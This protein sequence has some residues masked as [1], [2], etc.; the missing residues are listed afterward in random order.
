MNSGECFAKVAA[1]LPG[2][3][4]R[5]GQVE[6]LQSVLAAYEEEHTLLVEAGTG[7]GKSLAYLIPALLWAAQH[8]EPTVI[9]T[10]TIA[11]QEQLIQKDIPFLLDALEMDLKA[12][13]A[14]GMNNYVC[15]RKLHD[16]PTEVPESLFTWAKTTIEGSRSE[17]PVYP[18]QDLWD[19]IGAEAESCTHV[20]CPH[21]KECFFFKARR[22]AAD[23]HV[24]VA[25]HHLLF[26]DLAVREESDNFEEAA[27][28]PP[29]K[30][31]IL[32]EAHHI[33]D[34]ATHYFAQS[35]S[36]RGLIHALG[37][38]LSDRG[39]GKLVTLHRKICEA[40]P[41][42]DILGDKLTVILPAEKRNMVELVNEAFQALS[43]YCGTAKG[44]EKMRI[45]DSHLQDPVWGSTV[46][47]AIEQV[48]THGKGFLQT[49][50]SLEGQ[51][52]QKKDPLLDN[53][54]DGVLAEIKGICSRL[55]ASLATLFAFVF[56][57]LEADKVRWMEGA[58]PDLHL[59]AADLEIAQRL[60]KAL[61]E[62]LPTVVLCSATLSTHKDFSFIKKRLGIK[63]A[64]EKI[65]ASPFDYQ[66]QAILSVPT[67][68][69]DP[70]HPTF[71][72]EAAEKIW[73]TIEISKGGTFVLFTSYSM[74]R[75]CERLLA[76]RMHK[77]RYLL[78]CQGEENRSTLLRKF[79]T[80]D[81][82]VL[83]GTDSFWEGVD[84]AGDA[85]RCVIIVK[86]PF[87]VPNDP[88]FQARSEAIASQGGS[89][90][91]EYSLPHAIVKFKQGFGRL[92]RNKQD[93]GCVICLDPRLI[94]K[95][96]GKKFLKSLPPCPIISEPAAQCFES[97]KK[98]YISGT[99]TGF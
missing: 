69:P 58:P 23:A 53:K 54:C 31:L 40:Y 26:A 27:V 91:F 28:L 43:F 78:F 18:S 97:L 49:L 94:K 16:T 2:F 95:G 35:V 80:T 66:T 42:G 25:N 3:E 75:E 98:F 90:F 65:Y 45:R 37:R 12:V 41:L 89:P 46:Q 50:S 57:P 63:Q 64:E 77:K 19:Q 82:A 59:I 21:Y 83:F 44:E 60:S 29:Y 5:E 17:L 20:K 52:K 70:A 74:L 15:L 92:I 30:R 13:L 71:T 6:M 68:L 96:Y 22:Q 4:V 14:K 9:A 73:E 38:L 85:L 1:K 32:D 39:T 81:K 86:L 62:R 99:K 8:S 33:E 56:S 34:V 47:P 67:D 11:L 24:I 7:T 79:R 55:E 36:R 61:F 72:R 84:V 93:R 88:L 51:L 48:I 76:E 10:H 87:K